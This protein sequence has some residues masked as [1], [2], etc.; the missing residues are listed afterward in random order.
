[1]VDTLD[2]SS[3]NEASQKFNLTWALVIFFVFWFLDPLVEG[4]A[5]ALHCDVNFCF[6]E[7]GE[8][9]ELS[10]VLKK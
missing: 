3:D 9:I 6:L 7:G 4:L 8:V 5:W 10:S 1:M 2:F